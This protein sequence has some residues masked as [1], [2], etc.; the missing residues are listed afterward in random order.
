MARFMR[1]HGY[2]GYD[3]LWRW[4]VEDLEAFWAS[5]WDY[6]GVAGRLRP[7]ARLARD[8]G[9]AVVPGRELNYAE[10]IFRDKDPT[11]VA[12]LHASELRELGAWTWGELRE[13]TARIAAGLRALG[14]E[15]GDRVAAYM[16]NI[17][18]TVAAFLATASLGAVWSSCSPDF[19][20][21]SV[22]DRF[23]QIEPKVLLA[24]DGYRYGG[25]DFDRRETVEEIAAEIGGQ[26]VRL[27]YL[28]GTG[29]QDGFERPDELDVRA[30]AVRPPAVG[31]LLLGHDR[32]AEGDRARAGRDP[33]RAPQEAAPARRRA[34]R[35]PRLL[36]HDDRL[37]DVELPRRR[38]AD[39]RVDRA[40]RRQPRPPGHGRAVGPRRR[41]PA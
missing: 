37:D 1:E 14:V 10:H 29:W 32:P 11:R 33:A 17:P 30:G 12:I 15:R 22:I 34:G 24:V 20:A 6:F 8:A 41:A 7:G 4:S 13:Q 16:P 21:R 25:R 27:G 9:R 40:L 28:D 19:G 35:R 3:E 38:A 31:P 36:V 23:A 18:E 2:A 26:V 5:I 39:R